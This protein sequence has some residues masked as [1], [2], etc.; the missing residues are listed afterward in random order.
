VLVH[1]KNEAFRQPVLNL[2]IART[3]LSATD[4]E[5]ARRT[6]QAAMDSM[7]KLRAL[8]DRSQPIR[9]RLDAIFTTATCRFRFVE[10][11]K[12]PPRCLDTFG[13]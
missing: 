10:I 2:Q 8:C 12:G 13:V 6:W 11:Q 3:Y 5:I 7:A 4:P 1:S 9:A